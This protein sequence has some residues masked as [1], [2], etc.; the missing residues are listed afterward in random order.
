MSILAAYQAAFESG[1]VNALDTILHAE[2]TFTPHVGDTVM[3]KEDVLAFAGSG[4]VRTERH[5]V[6]YE[7]HEIGVEHAIAHFSND[8]TSE[9]VLSFHRFK[10]GKIISTE[11]GATPLSEDYTLIGSDV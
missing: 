8:S 2:F 1:D 10:D 5:R 7:N 11:T 6:L 9:A 3:R 4:G